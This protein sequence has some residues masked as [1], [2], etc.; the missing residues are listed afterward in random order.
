[1]RT[2][3]LLLSAILLPATGCVPCTWLLLRS[4]TNLSELKTQDQVQ[5]AFGHTTATGQV[6]GQLFEEYVTHRKIAEPQPLKAYG[7]LMS[8][9]LTWGFGEL[10]WFP[11]E[12][13]RTT[14]RSVVG[15]RL[16]FTYD[17]AGNVTAIHSDGVAILNLPRA[18]PPT[19]K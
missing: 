17:A 15:Q 19:K 11:F 4:G 7:A 5:E 16:R 3:C 10:I 18:E 14:Y 9:G 8:Y 12:L 2:A 13:S 6:D 1:V